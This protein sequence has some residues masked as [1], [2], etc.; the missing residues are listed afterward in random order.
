MAGRQAEVLLGFEIGTG[1][2]IHVPIEHTAVCGI[3]QKSGKT[4]TLDALISRSQRRAVA[5]I[6]KRSEGSFANARNIP[7]YFVERADWQFVEAILEAT[8]RE[9]MKYDRAWI[10]RVTRGATTLKDVQN[11]VRTQMS[12]SRGLSENVY[13]QLNEYFKLIMPQVGQVQMQQQPLALQPGIN[14]MDLVEYSMEMQSLVIGSVLEAVYKRMRDTTVIIP[15]AWEFC[16]QTRNT[17]VKLAAETFIRKTAAAGNFL[18]LDSQDLSGVAKAL[19]KQV[20]VW[21]LGVQREINEVL[22]TLDQIPMSRKAKPKPEDVMRLKIG[23]FYVCHGDMVKKVYVCPAWL[24]PHIAQHYAATGVGIEEIRA[25]APKRIERAEVLHDHPGHVDGP[26]LV[27]PMRSMI[28]GAVGAKD[29]EDFMWKEKYDQLKIQYDTLKRGYDTLQ[30]R[31]DRLEGVSDSTSVTVPTVNAVLPSTPLPGDEEALYQRIKARLLSDNGMT[32]QLAKLIPTIEY[33]E[34]R[35]VIRT[36]H[37]EIRGRVA[38]LI[39]DGF[40]SARKT[41]GQ[42]YSEL[43]TRGVTIGFKGA[44]GQELDKLTEMG[45]FRKEQLPNRSYM[46]ALVP[47]VEERVKRSQAA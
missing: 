11:N 47:G 22:H 10:I 29:E 32:L 16:P 13:I 39:L 20:S 45:F 14:V 4:T 24:R 46:F 12:K 33:T 23:E 5:F 38:E 35:E 30:S 31:V 40:F 15:E 44:V 3:T 7:P 26:P 28:L 21:I 8:M 27:E 36:N 43:E 25:R 1:D 9:K 2:P 41:S 19:L 18:W 6:T 34:S 17:P 42:V 37:S